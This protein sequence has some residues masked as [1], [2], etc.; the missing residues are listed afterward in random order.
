MET[1]S[2]S[3]PRLKVKKPVQIFFDT[4]CNCTIIKDGTQKEFNTTL[5]NPGPFTIDVTSGVR[6]YARGE[7]GLLLVDGS[8]QAVCALALDKVV[9]EMPPLQ[10]KDI[11][12]YL[13][14]QY[15]GNKELQEL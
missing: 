8:F 11:L 10:F 4:V 3:F 13:K 14:V 15:K 5:L 6:V 2:L 9:T 1:S 7:W 12:K